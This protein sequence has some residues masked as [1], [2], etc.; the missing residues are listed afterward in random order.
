LSHRASLEGGRTDLAKGGV[1]AP[2][3][4]EHFDVIEQLHLGLAAAVKAI[5]QLA[6][7]G[8][9]KFSITALS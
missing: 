1:P 4:I 9:K 2:L 5:P 3:V 7:T 6:L 8:E